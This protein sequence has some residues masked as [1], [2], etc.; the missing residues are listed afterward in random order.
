MTTES[1]SVSAGHFNLDES[2]DAVAATC[3]GSVTG[4]AAATPSG[5]SAAAAGSGSPSRRP[6]SSATVNSDLHHLRHSGDSGDS[7]VSSPGPPSSEASEQK[8]SGE[9]EKE[10]D[11]DEEDDRGSDNLSYR[12]RVVMEVVESETVYVRDLQQV[13]EGYLYFWRDEGERAPLSPE[14]AV[15]LFG[16]V[17][18]IYR[19]N[20][21]F[22]TQLQSYGLDPVEV[23]RCFVR[24]NS[25]FTIYTDYCTNYPRKVSVLTDLMRNEA[26]SRACH[27][28]QT[29]LQHTLPLGSYLLKPVQRILKYHLLLQNIVKH[30][31]R[32]Q[33]PG[34]TDIIVALS[35]MT[36]IAHHINDMKRKHEHA[37]RVQEVQSLLDLRRTGGRGLVPHV[38]SQGATPRFLAG[39]HVAHRQAKGERHFGLQSSHH[40][41]QSHPD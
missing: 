15:A 13:V 24:N 2:L 12:D 31:D 5:A 25:G 6:R 35:A 41:F 8:H 33:T 32:S 19:F 34:Y 29:Q 18:D 3:G 36:G 40:V 4:A 21:Q 17:D 27:E 22:L 16:N 20:S 37:V 7:G 26:A 28:R 11:A 9:E 39:S 23:A 1:E 10:E 14:Q 30:C 38:R